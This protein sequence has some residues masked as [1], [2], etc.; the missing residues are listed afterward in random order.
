MISS[1]LT[2]WAPLGKP[3]DQEP[4][5]IFVKTLTGGTLTT[6]CFRHDTIDTV[7][8][9]L[10]KEVGIPPD[11]QG[12]IFAGKQ[13][14]ER[15]TLSQYNIQKVTIIPHTCII[16]FQDGWDELY[17]IIYIISS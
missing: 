5:E 3:E 6:R 14:E 4:L 16:R 12:L 10:Q 17:L 13:L 8:S 9:L 2:T 15:R 1:W 7:K 11:Q